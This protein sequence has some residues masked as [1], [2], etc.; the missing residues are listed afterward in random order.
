MRRLQPSVTV[1]NSS[2]SGDGV[3]HG[4]I[5]ILTAVLAATTTAALA[6]QGSDPAPPPIAREFRGVWVATVA[7]IDWPSRPGLP[8]ADQ[9]RE[10]VAM[11]DRIK[12]LG[13]NAV[14][15]QVRPGC[16]ALYESPL[17]PWSEYLTGK[18]GEPPQPL[19]DPL[20]F[21]VEEAHRRGMELHAWI[22][23]YRARHPSAKSPVS[24]SHVSRTHPEF[25]RTYGKHLWLEPTDEGARKHTLS[26]VQDLVKRYDLDGI[27]IDDYFYPYREKEGASEIPFPDDAAWGRYR[28]SGGMLSRDDWR[29]DAVDTLIR[30]MYDVT[31]AT[32]PWVKVGISPFGI[33]RPGNPQ[34][35]QGFDAYSVLYADARKWVNEGWLDYVSP[36]LYWRI[37]P[38]AQ[39]YPVLQ[40]WWQEQNLKQRHLWPGLYT[41]RAYGSDAVWPASEIANQIRLTRAQ[42]GATGNIHFSAKALMDPRSALAQTLRDRVYSRPA[43]PPASPWLSSARPDS[44][45]LTLD[46]EPDGTRRLRWSG[47]GE[48]PVR[49]WVLKTRS[50]GQWTLSVIPAGEGAGMRPLAGSVDRVTLSAI[51]RYGSE[52]D[53]TEMDIK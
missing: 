18:M 25:T 27:H 19:Y 48:A 52:S 22:N 29:R 42:E 41:S 43:I 8:S 10:L 6:R 20:T 14:V 46:L 44:P 33:W 36:Q 3:R 31:K 47:R 28:S 1:G 39:S 17:E 23:P 9:Q 35:I 12:E 7:N 4:W 34:Q 30:E 21:A 16:D 2:G 15:F 32:K 51:D 26:V 37:D 49:N 53:P 11:F 50:G 24:S 45:Q 38:P 40:R 5:G 13:F